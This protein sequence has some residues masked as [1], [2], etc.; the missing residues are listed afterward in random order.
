MRDARRAAP[1]RRGGRAIR[2][3]AVALL[4]LAA[5][6]AA[7]AAPE[8]GSADAPPRSHAELLERLAAMRGFSAE[9]EETKTI[10]LLA[11]PLVSEGA[12]Y[13]EAPG[14]LLRHTRTPTESRVMI[15]RDRVVLA[16]GDRVQEIDLAASAPIRPLVESLLW[17]LAGRHD[18]IESVYASRYAVDE[19]GRG[20]TLRLSP[21]GAPLDQ[22][23]TEIVVTG[24]GG[25]PATFEVVEATGDRSLTRL[26][27]PDTTRRFSDEERARLFD[28]GAP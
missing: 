25:T 22:L 2:L 14:R 24:V 17:I 8:S 12:L 5:T 3:V 23:I 26:I 16:E 18:E 15:D 4:G 10:G 21:R 28:L 7:E 9:F 6:A 1:R 27:D 13:F 20:W 19:D 11:L